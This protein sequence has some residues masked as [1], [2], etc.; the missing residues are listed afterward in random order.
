[1]VLAEIRSRTIGPGRERPQRA[2]Q[3]NVAWL[4]C[5]QEEMR[6]CCDFH[7]THITWQHFS[8]SKETLSGCL[9]VYWCFSCFYLRSWPVLLSVIKYNY[10]AESNHYY[11][12]SYATSYASRKWEVRLMA[13]PMWIW[14]SGIEVETGIKSSSHPLSH[15]IED[16]MPHLLKRKKNCSF[17]LWLGNVGTYCCYC[18]QQNVSVVGVINLNLHQRKNN[19]KRELIE[20]FKL[21]SRILQL[22]LGYFIHLYLHHVSIQYYKSGWRRWIMASCACCKL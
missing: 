21:P 5:T 14:E 20:L 11:L 16:K 7:L 2:E 3:H 19:N 18:L 1:M 6:P 8:Y 17:G 12:T 15:S 22:F 9:F 13:L 4:C 10:E